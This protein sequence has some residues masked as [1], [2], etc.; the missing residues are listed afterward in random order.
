V[1][2][3]DPDGYMISSWWRFSPE[4]EQWRR[5]RPKP[6]GPAFEGADLPCTKVSWYEAV[7]FCRWL[8]SKS[9]LEIMLPTEQ[10]WQRAA[11]GDDGR[12]YPWGDEFDPSRCNFGN[13]VGGPTPVTK[14]PLG[15]SPYG[16]M[17]MSGNTWE[18]CLNEWGADSTRLKGNGVRGVRGGSWGFYQNLARAAA[19]NWHDPGDWAVNQSFR[20][21]LTSPIQGK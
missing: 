19:R 14:Y 2:I 15:A 17:N 8:S 3:D 11:Q 16:V 20:I 21:A 18:W 1:F 4:A 12:E 7:A 6:C 10:Q 13:N 5:D 9:G